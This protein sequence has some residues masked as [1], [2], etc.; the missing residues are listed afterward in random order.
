MKTAI[1]IIRDAYSYANVIQYNAQ[2][3][4]EEAAE[5]L[6]FLNELL[7]RWNLDD[8]FPFAV[9][10]IDAKVSGGE[11]TMKPGGDF[12]GPVPLKVNSLHWL[13]GSQWEP[14]RRVSYSNIWNYR[15]QGSI[16]S[17][18]AFTNDADG[19]GLLTF[20]SAQTNYTIRAI[21]NRALGTMGYNDELNAPPQYEQ[22][23]KYGIADK[24]CT[25]YGMPQDVRAGIK[26]EMDAAL[27]AVRKAN[28]FK[29]EVNP[30]VGTGFLNRAEH[31]ATIRRL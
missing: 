21:Y 15:H 1:Q 14:L 17:A 7:Y 31:I 10:T 27:R 11:A 20:D 2:L 24:C 6:G 26:G 19:T 13:N 12:D 8:Y 16:P 9:N 23:L 5:G 22:L 3:T 25:R 18:Y 30:Q 4:A 28:S 29:H